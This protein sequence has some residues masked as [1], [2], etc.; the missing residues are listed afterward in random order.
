MHFFTD[1]GLFLAKIITSVIAILITLSGFIAISTKGKQSKPKL[2]IKKINDTLDETKEAM[3]KATQSKSTLKEQQKTD[4]KQKKSL[5]KNKDE[6]SRLFVID[7]NGDI[8]ASGTQSLREEITAILLSAHKT[9]EVLVRLQSPGGLVNAY[10]LAS[11]QLKRI[12][13]AGIHL[14][15]A[16][17]KMA[18]SGGYMMACV[19]DTLIA[20]PFAIIGSIGV[21]AKLPNFHKLLTKNHIEYEQITAGEYKRTLTMLGKNT[22]AGRAKFQEE[23][24]I[25]QDLFKQHIQQH[26]P[27]LDINKVATGEHWFALQALDLQLIDHIQTSD[28]YLMSK[29]TSH[30]LFHIA[31]QAKASAMQKLL[32]K[33]HACAHLLL[34]N[35]VSSGGKDFLH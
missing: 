18:A 23:I 17:D 33:A 13:D 4:K 20:A 32:K 27:Q 19:A 21:V 10:G 29:K 30:H 11:S 35:S 25:T 26:R 8:S 15:I 1:Y 2:T 34:N 12:K 3:D 24:N 28:D 9:D 22:S 5:K 7:F 14:T 6:Q 31:Q 16:V